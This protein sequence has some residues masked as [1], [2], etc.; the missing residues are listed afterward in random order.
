VRASEQTVLNHGGSIH[1]FSFPCGG[2]TVN[3]K[4]MTACFVVATLLFPVAV[5]AAEPDP[6]RANPVAFVK[7]SVITAKVKAKLAAEEMHSLARIGVDTDRNGVVVLSGTVSNQQRA[8][9]AVAIARDTEGVT[10]VRNNI[11]IQKED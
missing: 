1:S 2:L 3:T 4:L 10:S 9:K 11:R 7:D 8:D 6:D 5:R